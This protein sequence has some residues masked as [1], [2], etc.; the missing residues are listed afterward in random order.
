MHPQVSPRPS[1]LNRGLTYASTRV[2]YGDEWERY[3][4]RV[5]YKIT[6]KVY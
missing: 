6:P 5:P 4:E 1:V 2:R 3:K